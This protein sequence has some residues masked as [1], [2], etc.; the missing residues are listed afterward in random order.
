MGEAALPKLSPLCLTPPP[1]LSHSSKA[2][3]P[4]IVFIARHGARLDAADKDWHLTSPTPYDPPLSYGGWLQARALGVRIASLLQASDYIGTGPEN[5]S[6]STSGRAAQLQSPSTESDL[7]DRYN[8]VIHTSP[9]LR[10][11][12]TSIAVSAGINQFRSGS[13]APDDLGAGPLPMFETM[14]SDPRTLLRVDAFLGEWL[15]PDYFDQITPPPASDRMV[16]LAKAELLRR[17]DAI[18]TPREGTRA[19]S[20]HFP[21]G[22]GSHS[23]PPSPSENDDKRLQ[24][25]ESSVILGSYGQRQR[26]N[27]DTIQSPTRPKGVSKRLDRLYTDLPS[28]ADSAYVPPTPSYAV[29]PSDP[30]PAGYVA[31]ARD[32]C[33]KVDYMWDS[34]RAPFWGTG[35]EY[36]EEWSSMHERVHD[37]FRQMIEW[38]RQPKN[39]P[40]DLSR[41]MSHGFSRK[42]GNA[43]TVVII[44]SHG[45]DCNALISSLAGHSA[46]LDINTASLT[47]AVRQDRLKSTTSNVG[48]MANTSGH[49]ETRSVA[50]EY[51]L[52]LVA[53]TDHLR[54]GVNPSKLTSLPSPSAPPSRPAAAVPTYRNRLGSRPTILQGPLAI[55]PHSM[56]SAPARKSS[57]KSATAATTTNTSTSPS[58]STTTASPAAG[59]SHSRTW[60]M[61]PRTSLPLR[62]ISGLWGSMASPTVRND[63]AED[64][65][66][67]FNDPRPPVQASTPSDIV[68]DRSG[69]TNPLPRRTN[70]QRGLWGSAASLEGHDATAPRRWTV[71]EQKL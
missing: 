42:N 25:Q 2:E 20:G 64:L 36:G 37:G 24:P 60:S 21:G 45:A 58:P 16:A 35:G 59:G 11:L 54:A 13:E 4:P 66:P 57:T 67:N 28:I 1:P 30:I 63:E 52:Q 9:F 23:N 65:M 61:A 48:H 31:H 34:M 38:Y 22:W 56:A 44:I 70:S 27:S 3:S 68:A 55:R 10:C 12:Q 29:S 5:Q 8:V 69:W 51:A 39:A 6:T 14:A 26:A 62:G 53:S 32:A 41:T 71:A 17:G 33:T 18:F 46:L 40:V 47:M 50:Q 15:S 43:Q 49:H 19:L 7:F